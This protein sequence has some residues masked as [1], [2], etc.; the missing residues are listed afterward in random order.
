[1]R[2]IALC[3]LLLAAPFV[4]AEGLVGKDAPEFAANVT[5]KDTEFR[6]SADFAGDVVVLRFT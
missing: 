2:S 4:T 1:M 3:L 5:V 6:K